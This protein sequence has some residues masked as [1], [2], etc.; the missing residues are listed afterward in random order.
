MGDK[1]P[2][3]RTLPS[4][5]KVLHSPDGSQRLIPEGKADKFLEAL[6]ADIEQQALALDTAM[7]DAIQAK[8]E[9]LDAGEAVPHDKRPI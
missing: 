1:V 4:G 6:A 5:E 7:L 8:R 3:V 2:S 9:A